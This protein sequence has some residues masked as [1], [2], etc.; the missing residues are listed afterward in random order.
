MFQRKATLTENRPFPLNLSPFN[1]FNTRLF[2]QRKNVFHFVAVSSFLRETLCATISLNRKNKTTSA[3]RLLICNQ[4][5]LNAA[6][7]SF[8]IHLSLP[9]LLQVIAFICGLVVL[10]L[11]SLCIA[12]SNWYVC[13]SPHL[14][15]VLPRC[16]SAR[17]STGCSPGCSAR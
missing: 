4:T 11:M 10:V 1:I 13:L 9:L 5:D 14:R 6:P 12:S 3:T 8:L 15:L 2:E 16:C 17:Y 7:Y